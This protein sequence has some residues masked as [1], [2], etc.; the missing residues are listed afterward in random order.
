M[1]LDAG[2]ASAV[3]HDGACALAGYSLT[4]LECERLVAVAR[5][6]GMDLNC[7]LA[8]GNRFAPIVDFFPLTCEL[9]HPWLR[10]LLDELWSTRRPDNYQL[11]GED[12]AFARFIGER[13]ARGALPHPYAEEVFRYEHAC[14]ELAKSLRHVAPPDGPA[15]FRLAYFRHD[16][17][18]VLRALER[19]E[20]PPPGLPAGD[21]CVRIT[22]RGDALEVEMED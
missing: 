7:S 15:P 2:L 16:P 11:L 9:L 4:D 5:Q 13:A 3:R 17:R 21:Y 18:I 14:L 22:L 6:P 1:T 10:A 19:H 12:E 20:V 8:R